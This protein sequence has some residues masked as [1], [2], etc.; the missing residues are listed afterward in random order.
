MEEK[1]L[2]DMNI[3]LRRKY[4]FEM[5]FSTKNKFLQ[6]QRKILKEILS[7]FKV[8]LKTSLTT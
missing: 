6:I 4:S 1:Y 7:R 8:L 5:P 3:V 2:Q